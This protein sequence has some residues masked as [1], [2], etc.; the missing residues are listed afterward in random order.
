MLLFWVS[1]LEVFICYVDVFECG[2]IHDLTYDYL[3][4]AAYRETITMRCH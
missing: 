1:I 3:H 4:L 2:M